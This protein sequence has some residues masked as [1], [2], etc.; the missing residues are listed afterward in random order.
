MAPGQTFAIFAFSAVNSLAPTRA[1]MRL[2][3][4]KP[5]ALFPTCVTPWVTD[6]ESELEAHFGERSRRAKWLTGYDALAQY[7]H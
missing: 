4:M 5:M 1:V 2:R 7:S 3:S 6:N